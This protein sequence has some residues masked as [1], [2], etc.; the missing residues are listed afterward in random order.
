M[1]KGKEKNSINVTKIKVDVERDI[2]ERNSAR[3]AGKERG[4]GTEKRK[5][6]HK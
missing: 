5:G 2:R 4:K 1:N 6:N 3:T